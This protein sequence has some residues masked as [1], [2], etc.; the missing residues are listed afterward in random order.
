VKQTAKVGTDEGSE[1]RGMEEEGAVGGVREKRREFR[2]VWWDSGEAEG[3]SVVEVAHLENSVVVITARL[4]TLHLCDL[5]NCIVVCTPLQSSA[6]VRDCSHCALHLAAHQIR[7]HDTTDSIL[8]LLTKENALIEH[9]SGLSVRP[10]AVSHPRMTELLAECQLPQPGSRED[11]WRDVNDMD[12][13]RRGQSPNWT[14]CENPV[15]ISC[16]REPQDAVVVSQGEGGGS[17][18]AHT[19]PHK[20]LFRAAEEGSSSLIFHTHRVATKEDFGAV[21]S[22]SPPCTSSAPRS[23]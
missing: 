21:L 13:L 17:S 23:G 10:Y 1:E 9:C 14:P 11:R 6:L 2:N 8:C 18:V 16:V 19:V 20:Q 4:A 12:C 22:V 5:H 15:K 7:I 3:D